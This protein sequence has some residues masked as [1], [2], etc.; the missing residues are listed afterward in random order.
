M[1]YIQVHTPSSHSIDLNKEINCSP[2]SNG[3]GTLS[4]TASTSLARELDQTKEIG[5]QEIAVIKSRHFLAV[6][7][8]WRGIVGET[9]LVNVYGPQAPTDKKTFWQNLLNLMNSRTDTWIFFGDFN[10]V[11]RPDERFNSTFCLNIAVAFNIFITDAG[12][13]DMN[14]G[15]R[16][17]TYFCDDEC[18]LSKLDRFLVCPNF[19]NAFPNASVMALPR[20]YSDHCPILLKTCRIDFG[21]TPFRFF[22]SW[23]YREDC[24]TIVKTV[25][26][27]FQGGGAPDKYLKDKLRSVKEALKSWR[28]VTFEKEHKTLLDLKLK[29]DSIE[30]EPREFIFQPPSIPA[31]EDSS[32]LFKRFPK[33]YRSRCHADATR[34][35]DSLCSLTAENRERNYPTH[36]LELGAVVF[37]LKIWRHY[38]YGVKCIIYTDHKSLKYLFDQRDLNMRQIRWLD[39]VKDYDCEIHYH[40]GKANVVADALSRKQHVEPIRAKCDF[41]DQRCVYPKENVLVPCYRVNPFTHKRLFPVSLFFARHAPNKN[42]KRR[43]PEF[44][45]TPALLRRAAHLPCSSDDGLRSPAPSPSFRRACSGQAKLSPVLLLKLPPDLFSGRPRLPQF[46]LSPTAL[47]YP[48][49]LS[50]GDPQGRYNRSFLFLRVFSG[51]IKPPPPPKSM[52]AGGGG[53]ISVDDIMRFVKYFETH[54]C[55]SKGCNLSFITLIPKVKDPLSLN[56]FRPI[57]L[58]GCVYKIIAKTLATRLKKVIE[59]VIDEV[60]TAFIGGRNILDGPMVIN[61]VCNWAKKEKHKAFLFKVDFD[62]TFDSINWNY[63]V[64]VMKQMGFGEKWICWIKGCLSSSRAS[65]ITNGS[66]TKDFLITRGFRQGDPLSP[67]LFIIAMEGLNVAMKSKDKGGL[68]EGSLKS[69]NW[70]LLLKW[71]W[72]FKKDPN[73][74]WRKVIC[75][76]HNCSRKP[77]CSWA[78]K[79]LAGT[80]SDIVKVVPALAEIGIN[81]Q[82][83]LKVKIGS[84]SDIL[85]WWDDW[86]ELGYLKTRFPMLFELDRRKSCLLSK[87]VSSTGFQ[88]RWKRRPKDNAELAE[89]RDLEGVVNSITIRSESYNLTS[90]LSTDG[91]YHVRDLRDLIESCWVLI[92]GLG[93][94]IPSASALLRR[95]ITVPNGRCH[96]CDDGEDDTNHFLVDCPTARASLNWILKWCNIQEQQFKTVGEMVKFAAIWGNYSKKRKILL[97]IIYGYL[98]CTWKARNDKVF[99]NLSTSPSKLADNIVT[100]VFD[101]MKYRGNFGNCNWAE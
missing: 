55:F 8:Y 63:L 14:M 34:Q 35:G 24:D 37:A 32:A 10:A 12:L 62:K 33:F 98:W 49:L 60:Q 97:A 88:G 83:I 16:K 54:G 72:R 90:S 52:V 42:P 53:F 2:S 84:G 100:L 48:V 76:I 93:F 65:V 45:R 95:G 4:Q 94:L 68:G 79:T 69:L 82:S 26:E 89:Q 77:T 29:V 99:N 87:R 96:L 36:D 58:I 15:G 74:L 81:F 6:V 13:L 91:V 25:W 18:K 101:W 21:P 1:I 20:E 11:R 73:S 59:T 80:W 3:C 64:S 70:A 40:P 38:L 57:S 5:N 92:C 51:E 41:P 9:I 78:K 7:G 23:L 56:D 39:V 31:F 47:L 46:F 61:E 28:R 67:F 50:S 75:G 30:L 22:N 43:D 17:F 44:R 85:F 19:M 86:T 66:P 27:G 71:L